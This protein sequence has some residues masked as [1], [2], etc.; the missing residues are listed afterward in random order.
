VRF[1]EVL[2]I[3]FLTTSRHVYP[4][5]LK[6]FKYLGPERH[7]EHQALFDN[8]IVFT[9]YATV[10][11]EKSNAQSPFKRINWF[12]IVLDEGTRLALNYVKISKDLY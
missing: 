1:T 4:G 8:D 2:H 5:G 12:R 3:V 11:K 10:A 9:T 6:F 7:A